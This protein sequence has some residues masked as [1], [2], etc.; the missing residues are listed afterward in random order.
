MA[1]ERGLLDSAV[2][3]VSAGPDLFADALVSQ[4]A[5]VTRVDWQP[6]AAERELATLWRDEVDGANRWQ[7]FRTMTLP[8]LQPLIIVTVLIRAMDIFKTFDTVYVMTG[9]GPGDATET[10]SFY[11]YLQGLRFFSFGYAAAVSYIQ[12]AIISVVATI[13]VRRIRKGFG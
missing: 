2:V 11:T 10:A 9:G 12:L 13:L 1:A 4:R 7:L 5:T 6:P 8:L 3:A